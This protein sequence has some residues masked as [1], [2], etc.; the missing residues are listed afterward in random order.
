VT[1]VAAVAAVTAVVTDLLGWPM[2]A[3]GGLS[4]STT[5]PLACLLGLIP[6]RQFVPFVLPI[7][8]AALEVAVLTLIGL[9]TGAI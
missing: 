3:I 5:F 8:L 4:V 7:T 2:L 9:H 6:Q 1:V